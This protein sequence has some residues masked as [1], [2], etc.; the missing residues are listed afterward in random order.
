MRQQLGRVLRACPD[1]TPGPSR[2]PA[3]AIFLARRRATP[4]SQDGWTYRQARSES[5]TTTSSVISA[6]TTGSSPARTSPRTPA[7]AHPHPAFESL[8]ASLSATQ[9]CFGAR[10]DEV[11]LLTGPGEFY[12]GLIEMIKRARRRIFISSLYIGA[13]EAELVR[14]LLT[15]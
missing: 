3:S 12:K 15:L 1:A 10:G 14:T 7:S 13:E 5:S 9:P 6:A 8:A 11:K 2:L 4:R